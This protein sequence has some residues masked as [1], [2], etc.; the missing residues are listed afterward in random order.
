MAKKKNPKD[1]MIFLGIT[2]NPTLLERLNRYAKDNDYSVSF[3]IRE[4]LKKY[5]PME[6]YNDSK[7]I[8]RK[9]K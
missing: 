3:I 9:K 4:A 2:I 6:Y 7:G 8:L 1:K 5:L